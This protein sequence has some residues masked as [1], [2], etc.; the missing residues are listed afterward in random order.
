MCFWP[1]SQVTSHIAFLA[2]LQIVW[3]SS[4]TFLL[5]E[6]VPTACWQV[7]QRSH[8]IFPRW[9][10]PMS[11]LMQS[12]AK[13][14]QTSDCLYCV[15]STETPS[16]IHASVYLTKQ[17]SFAWPQGLV[18]SSNPYFYGNQKWENRIGG[19]C[20]WAKEMI[21]PGKLLCLKFPMTEY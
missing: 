10:G 1:Q 4:Q 7:S 19:K 11:V 2:K 15:C 8:V 9:N 18:L 6:M 14:V 20:L 12:L 17:M 21:V 5:E 3:C 13:T 16:C